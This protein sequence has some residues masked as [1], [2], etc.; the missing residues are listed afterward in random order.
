LK[1]FGYGD[2]FPKRAAS[3]EAACFQAFASPVRFGLSASGPLPCE[4]RTRVLDAYCSPLDVVLTACVEE[5][6]EEVEEEDEAAPLSLSTLP[7]FC[8]LPPATASESESC[9]STQSWSSSSMAQSSSKEANSSSTAEKAFSYGS[10]YRERTSFEYQ[11][12][13]IVSLHGVGASG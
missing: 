3:L 11:E 2:T 6:L 7:E 8:T 10:P 4:L 1:R 9:T 12:Q 5:E 13:L